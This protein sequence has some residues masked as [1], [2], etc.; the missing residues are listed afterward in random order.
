MTWRPGRVEPPTPAF[1]EL[2]APVFPTTSMVAVGLPN[3]G[4]CDKTRR[5]WVIVVGD[6][7]KQEI[8]DLDLRDLAPATQ[9]VTGTAGQLTADSRR[10][11][12]N[13]R[14]GSPGGCNG[15]ESRGMV[16]PYHPVRCALEGLLDV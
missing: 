14:F 1:S 15:L 12:S 11:D 9:S 2:I 16:A 7:T 5:P 3:T 6:P 8:F 10:P 13:H 4:G